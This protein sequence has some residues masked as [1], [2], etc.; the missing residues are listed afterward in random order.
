MLRRWGQGIY[1]PVNY[2]EGYLI[3]YLWKDTYLLKVSLP[4]VASKNSNIRKEANQKGY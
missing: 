2:L 4:R 3:A 1:N